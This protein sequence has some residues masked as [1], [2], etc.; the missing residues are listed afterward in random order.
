MRPAPQRSLYR[1]RIPVPCRLRPGAKRRNRCPRFGFDFHAIGDAAVDTETVPLLAVPPKREHLAGPQPEHQE[2]ADDEKVT[3]AQVEQDLG[4]LFRREVLRCLALSGFRY[5]ELAGG[6]LRQHLQFDRFVEH[7]I[8]VDTDF[9][10]NALRVFR[11]HLVEVRLQ[12]KLMQIAEES[13]SEALEQV[14]LDEA[15]RL[16]PGRDFS[17]LLLLWQEAVLVKPPKCDV[18]RRRSDIFRPAC[19]PGAP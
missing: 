18:H 16:G 13:V 5:R 19:A 2:H 9:R 17:P 7:G 1:A 14:V 4:N 6:I 11:R 8:E 3:V 15:L 12:R 10:Q